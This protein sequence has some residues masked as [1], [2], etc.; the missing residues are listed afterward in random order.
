V[1]LP[2][3]ALTAVNVA[4]VRL[5]ADTAVALV[6]AK[7]VPLVVFAAAGAAAFV[8]RTFL[9]QV[10][11]RGATGAA[12]MGEAA[13]LLLFAYAGFEN[14][15]APA[16]EYR[17]PRRDVPFALVVQLALVT[18]L[19]LAVQAVALG[20][21]PDLGASASPLAEAAGRFLGAGGVALLSVGA[22]VSILG[23]LNDSVLAGPR[24]LYALARDGFGPAF[25]ARVHPRW[26]TPAAAILVQTAI[27][28]PL[29]LSGTFVGLAA[30]SVVARLA[31][32]LGTAAAVPVLRR[33]AG[34]GDGIEDGR[35]TAAAK[36]G[37]VARAWRLPGGPVI[38]AAAALVTLGLAASAT[39]QNLLAAGV[40]VLVGLGIYALRRRPPEPPP[41][42]R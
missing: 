6:L 16:G 27:A 13:L 3:L 1:A 25:L 17:D 41:D 8:P 9:S 37:A 24:Y 33:R 22:V 30:L 26:R 40:A 23:T 5:G 15:A 38:P 35:R 28:L 29:A 32:Y 39:A 12:E 19:Y 4:G 31:T 18:A 7:S 34:K 14:T 2:L 20:T 11:T 21:L 10:A 42:L 36:E